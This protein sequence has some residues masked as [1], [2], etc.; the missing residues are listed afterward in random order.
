MNLD[1][2]AIVS[3]TGSQSGIERWGDYS[4]LSVDPSDDTTFWFTTEYQRSG[5]KTRIASFDFG[6]ILPPEVYAGNDT[7]ICEASAYYANSAQALYQQSIYWQTSGD[8]FFLDPYAVQATY[9]RG[10]NDMATGAV[11]LWADVTGYIQGQ[12]ASD[13]L[14]LSLSRK[15]RAN[16]GADTTICADETIMLSGT[17]QYQDSVFWKSDGDGTFDADTLLTPVYTPGPEDISKG[18]VWLRLFAYDSLPCAGNASDRVKITIDQCTGIEEGTENGFALSVVPNPA[19][20]QLN[21]RITGLSEQN[22]L[23]LTL[24]NASG[25]T[26]FSMKIT[27][28]DGQY[29]NQMNIERFPKGIYYMKASTQGRQVIQKVIIQ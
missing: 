29:S 20:G 5:W 12:T 9:L 22:D 18:Y 13:T 8:G 11:T 7:T 24:L 27:A 16:A 4:C 19:S 25:V 17:A 14:Q 21:F 23:T 1:E 15:A 3:G 26:V 10:Q 2:I 28:A 6:P